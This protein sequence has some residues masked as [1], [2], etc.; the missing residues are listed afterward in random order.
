MSKAFSEA[1]LV[2]VKANLYRDL[3]RQN[4]EE[5]DQVMQ[6]AFPLIPCPENSC[7]QAVIELF[8]CRDKKE[9]YIEINWTGN[10][11]ILALDHTLTFQYIIDYIIGCIPEISSFTKQG[12]KFEFELEGEYDTGE[13]YYTTE[14]IMR[15]PMTEIPLSQGILRYVVTNVRTLDNHRWFVSQFAEE[16][17]QEAEQA[18]AQQAQQALLNYNKIFKEHIILIAITF[19]I[20]SDLDHHDHSLFT[21]LLFFIIVFSITIKTIYT[22]EHITHHKQVMEKKVY[23]CFT[24]PGIFYKNTHYMFSGTKAELQIAFNKL[25]TDIEEEKKEPY[26]GRGDHDDLLDTPINTFCSNLCHCIDDIDKTSNYKCSHWELVS[27]QTQKELDHYVRDIATK[28]IYY[29]GF[30]TLIT[31]L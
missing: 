15:T 19:A 27:F 22:N 21:L 16:Q 23:M 6:I 31:Y 2:V 13:L 11:Y 7:G 1:T 8:E 5:M 10:L 12:Y 26:F 24:R 3:M 28:R 18:Q 30:P 4:N 25:Q 9:F 17:A 20:L 14:T 29:N